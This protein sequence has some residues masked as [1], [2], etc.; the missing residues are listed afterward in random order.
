VFKIDLTPHL[1][2]PLKGPAMTPLTTAPSVLIRAARGS[3]G[4]A[5][6]RLAALDSAVVPAGGLLVAEAEGE[7]VAALGRRGE[8]IA[9][10]FR[11][12]AGVLALLERRA[13]GSGAGRSRPGLAERLGLRPAPRARAA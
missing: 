2:T 9:D 8:R 11:R 13:A 6:E 1:P 10:P 5:L 3:D 4:P 7:L 12:T